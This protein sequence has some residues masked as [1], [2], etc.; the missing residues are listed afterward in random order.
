MVQVQDTTCM[1]IVAVPSLPCYKAC[2]QTDVVI[3]KGTLKTSSY[4]EMKNKSSERSGSG[5]RIKRKHKTALALAPLIQLCI[6]SEN[7]SA[8]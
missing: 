7:H 6:G 8:S 4:E 2:G 5:R 1:T 3:E